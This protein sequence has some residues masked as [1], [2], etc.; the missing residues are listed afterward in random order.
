MKG[1][2][3]IGWRARIASVRKCARCL[4]LFVLCVVFC[5]P[6]LNG[7]SVLSQ[8]TNHV[9]REMALAV[10]HSSTEFRVSRLRARLDLPRSSVP[11]TV[12]RGDK[13]VEDTQQITPVTYLPFVAREAG[14]PMRE[15]RALWVTRYDWTSLE[16]AARPEAL[17]E[18]V[19]KASGAGFNV[20]LFQVRAA[21]DAYYTPGLEPW[22]AR[23]SGGPI[24]ETLGVDPGW[25]PLAYLIDAA[26]AV[27]LEVHA[28]VNVYT[29]W[30]SPNDPT[31]GFLWPPA[32]TPPQMFDRFAYGPRYQAHPGEYGLGYT[33]RQYD[34]QGV[35]MPLQRGQYLWA[36]PGVDLVADHVT[37]V[38][39]DI[40][41]RYPV[42]G[43]HLDQVRYAGA[44]YSYDPFSI[45]SAGGEPSETRADWQ[46]DRVTMLV[47]RLR[48]AVRATRPE[49]MVS[50]AVWPYYVDRWG[51]DVTE[52]YHDLYQDSK[53]WLREGDV[54]AIVP[55]LYGGLCDDRAHWEFLAD[56]FLAVPATE[57][58]WVLPGI[59]AHY[60]DF[61]EIAW[62]IQLARDRGAAGHA[63][64][65]YNG[66]DAHGFW[67]DLAE[68]PYR[69]RAVV[70]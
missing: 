3:N 19:A 37:A 62:R 46:R 41:Q 55:M 57:G 6:E 33:W 18:I 11:L 45:E 69:V 35:P 38:V 49:A 43:L 30:Q 60:G 64:F 23:L 39:E 24:S 16:A 59:G 2:C 14:A 36:S 26:H 61:E 13:S 42:D 15:L 66:L 51:W 8:G 4:W 17:D 22:A 48:D 28:Y 58:S 70:P 9:F 31:E 44:Q 47:R 52:G 7:G 32:T 20:L 67:D 65:S 1:R 21:G 25:D 27:G 34:E 54:D 50:A 29:A 10:G 5:Q 63:I 68:G 53:R 12:L 40:I 56:D